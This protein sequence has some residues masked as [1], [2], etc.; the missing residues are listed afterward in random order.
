V[1]WTRLKRLFYERIV[2]PILFTQD[3]AR[4]KAGGVALGMFIAFTPTVGIQMPIAFVA[5]TVLG[6]NIPLAVAMVWLTN[7]LTVPPVYFSEYCVGTW[8][9][10]IDTIASKS[11]FW[12]Q[13]EEISVQ[14]P[15]YLERMRHLAQAILGPL[16]VGS[17][18]VALI[19]ALVSYPLTFWICQRTERRR[20]EH[21]KHLH[22]VSGEILPEP[23]HDDLGASSPAQRPSRTIPARTTDRT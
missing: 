20:A 22:P 6:V 4:S 7:P 1:A 21:P 3:T 15:G 16:L 11:E 2:R 17:L 19:L 12:H 18:L 10:G 8:L 13:W 14:Y 9:L 23:A 5:A